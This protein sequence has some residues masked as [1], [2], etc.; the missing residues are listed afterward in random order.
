MLLTQMAFCRA[1]AGAASQPGRWG[2]LTAD[3][4]LE[5]ALLLADADVQARSSPGASASCSLPSH[6]T[7]CG[8]LSYVACQR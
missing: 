4:L 3:L 5:V 2:H 8:K 7:S 6:F 1:P